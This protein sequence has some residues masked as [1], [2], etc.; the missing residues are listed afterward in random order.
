MGSKN[1]NYKFAIDYLKK[2]NGK[3]IGFEIN[4]MPKQLGG[5]KN[6]GNNQRNNQKLSLEKA[7]KEV[8]KNKLLF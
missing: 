8:P 5:E 3:W 4:F 2:L 7:P 6:Q 1:N